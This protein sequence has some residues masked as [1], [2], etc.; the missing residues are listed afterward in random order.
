[1]DGP[2]AIKILG[3]YPA[4]FIAGIFLLRTRPAGRSLVRRIHTLQVHLLP[5]AEPEIDRETT[6][7]RTAIRATRGKRD[8]SARAA[9]QLRDISRIGSISLNYRPVVCRGSAFFTRGAG[10]P[11]NWDI[12]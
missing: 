7:A 11:N 2:A 9:D 6:L 8:S 10:L 5:D 1:M 4:S 3:P 12:I